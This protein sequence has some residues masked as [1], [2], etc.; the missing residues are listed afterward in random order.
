MSRAT[1]MQNAER[2]LAHLDSVI[3][4]LYAKHPKA[5]EL[6]TGAWMREFPDLATACLYRA[7]VEGWLHA[8]KSGKELRFD[9]SHVVERLRMADLCADVAGSAA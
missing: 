1:E 7:E 9:F 3:A 2:A 8:A 5:A 4:E 6:W